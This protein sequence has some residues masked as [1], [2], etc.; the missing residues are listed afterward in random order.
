MLPL[1]R[2]ACSPSAWRSGAARAR[3]PHGQ[4]PGSPTAPPELAAGAFRPR[5][6]RIFRIV[7][8][9]AVACLAVFT[10]ACSGQ[11]PA[12]GILTGH[13]YEGVITR[14]RRSRGRTGR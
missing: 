6:V 5:E 1:G 13:L 9:L 3:S 4:V 12:G 7:L 10:A 14:F 11:S 8:S 2:V